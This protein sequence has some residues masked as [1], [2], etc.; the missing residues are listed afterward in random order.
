[1]S[2]ILSNKTANKIYGLLE[3]EWGDNGDESIENIFDILLGKEYTLYG[4]KNKSGDIRFLWATDQDEAEDEFIYEVDD[5]DEYECFVVK[6]NKGKEVV[7][8]VEG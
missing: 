7:R 2:I 4:F 5:Y 6:D 3:K 8:K 1:M